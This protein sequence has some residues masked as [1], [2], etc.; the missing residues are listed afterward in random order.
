MVRQHVNLY[1]IVLRQPDGISI[2]NPKYQGAAQQDDPAEIELHKFFQSLKIK[3]QA[4]EAEDPKTLQSAIQDINLR[5]RNPIR[6]I[7]KIS[8]RDYS[9]FF[10]LFA[11][12]MIALLLFI[13]FFGV[14]SW[15][16][17]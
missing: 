6:Y 11:T 16:Q 17:A 15:Q 4:Y 8:G 10:I 3:Y 9:P 2:F 1:W 14:K 12:F 13:K 7:E 5:E